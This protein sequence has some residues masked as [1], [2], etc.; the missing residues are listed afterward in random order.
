MEEVTNLIQ[1]EVAKEMNEEL[2][3]EFIAKEVKA[4][5]RQM[6]PTKAPGPDGMSAVLYQKY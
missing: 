1:A 5:L 4:A 6:H 2:T 3:K